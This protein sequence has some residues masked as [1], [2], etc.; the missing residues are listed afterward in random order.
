MK[1]LLNILK[2]GLLSCFVALAC[3]CNSSAWAQGL[4]LGGSNIG[5]IAADQY[6]KATSSGET[7]EFIDQSQKAL[8]KQWSSIPEI[9][10]DKDSRCAPICKYQ[11]VKVCTLCPLFAVV[12]NTVSAVGSKAIKAF[13]GSVAKVVLVGFGIWLAIQILAFASAIETRDLKD[14]MQSLVIQGFI[15]VVVVSIIQTG[16]SNFFNSFVAP[17][18]NTGQ[19]MAQTMYN[20]CAGEDKTACTASNTEAKET[21]DASASLIK[22]G[23][24]PT[25]MGKNIILTM[26]LMENK[27]RQYKAIGSSL[28]CESWR[29]SNNN[30]NIVPK[31][32][33]LFTGIGMWV[34]AM[35]LI[36]AVPLL[37]V[38][39]V[40]QLGV[41]MALMPI[42]VGGFAFKST[43]QYTKKVWET[44]LNSAFAFVFIAA[45]VLIILGTLQIVGKDTAGEILDFDKLFDA[46][47]FSDAAMAWKHEAIVENFGWGSRAFWRLCVVFLL[48]W[49]VM[50]MAK[51]FA[52]DFASSI[53]NTSI[54]SQI[55]TMAASSAKGMAVKAGKPVAKAT[56]KAMLSGGK[57]LLRGTTHMFRR[58]KSNKD[59]NKVEKAAVVNGKKTYVKG[60]QT[61]ELD[62]AT[63]VMRSIETKK[64]GDRIEKTTFN[65]MT[66]VKT[67]STDKNGNKVSGYKVQ[68]LNEKTENILRKDGSVD[69]EQL[70]K[71]FDG[72]KGQD[73]IE[74]K[75]AFARH[76]AAKRTT[77]YAYDTENAKIVSTEVVTDKNGEFVIKD[78]TASG[79]VVFTSMKMHSDTGVM[80]T[81]LT[82]IDKKGR[83]TKLS[84]DGIRNKMEEFKLKDGTDIKSLNNVDEVYANNA[85]KNGEIK[86]SYSYTKFY[87]DKIDAF[88]Y[89]VA[90]E[91]NNGMMTDEEIDREFVRFA[92]SAGNEHQKG[93]MNWNFRN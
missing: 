73:L 47:N 69:T 52:D 71:M 17:V 78:V 34:F 26:T 86:K 19:Y 50:N 29:T 22:Q 18:Y 84:S 81:G 58:A 54:G 85:D 64:N 42:A 37:L 12:F 23:S 6:S 65:G 35:L 57:R 7:K 89:G 62:V 4:G 21:M 3:G 53:S 28:M 13:S 48:A 20:S 61:I 76:A 24:L 43:R 36:L 39:S 87:Q 90:Q 59:R 72:L 55:G 77:R 63:G 88:G 10:V 93:R 5:M 33:I 51:S 56:G 15:V 14:L 8:M 46:N 38:D 41:A 2:I 79:E 66:V 75:T 32:S 40:F 60:N 44:V 74:A 49:S 83:V 80:E 16:V 9:C 92:H 31:F 1:K 11:A 45:V 82:K 25:S 30:W 70:K 67:T 27:V 68:M 91:F